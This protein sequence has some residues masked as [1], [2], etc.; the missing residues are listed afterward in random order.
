MKRLVFIGLLSV[1][2]GCNT[3]PLEGTNNQFLTGVFEIPG[4]QGYSKTIVERKD[5]LQIERYTKLVSISTDSGMVEKEELHVDTLFITWKN[6]FFYTLKMKSP[7]SDLDKDPIFVQITKITD[8]SYTFAA[9]IG[10]SKYKQ[11]GV[12]YKVH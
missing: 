12:L 9:K 3:P 4:G 1:I 2:M 11:E 8:S 6:N 10:F 5:S 7:K